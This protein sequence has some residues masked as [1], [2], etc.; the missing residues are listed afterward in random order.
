MP[1]TLATDQ[2]E[3]TE[4]EFRAEP[5]DDMPREQ[6]IARYPARLIDA[7]HLASNNLNAAV[8]FVGES[9]PREVHMHMDITH[10]SGQK[11]SVVWKLPQSVEGL[12]DE[13]LMEADDSLGNLLYYCKKD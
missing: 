12:S 2:D 4:V 7:L 5:Q 11:E 1:I 3:T 10:L 6:R 13:L 8:C 9:T